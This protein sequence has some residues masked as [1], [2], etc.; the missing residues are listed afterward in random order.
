VAP[1]TPAP[2]QVNSREQLAGPVVTLA[3]AGDVSP[4]T[5]ATPLAL[6]EFAEQKRAGKAPASREVRA[7]VAKGPHTQQTLKYGAATLFVLFGIVLIGSGGRRL[8]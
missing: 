7:G 2:S 4:A 3:F 6:G 1:P 8:T 5:R